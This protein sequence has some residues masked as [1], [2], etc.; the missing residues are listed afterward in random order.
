[1]NEQLGLDLAAEPSVDGV[2]PYWLDCHRNR[3]KHLHTTKRNGVWV[4]EWRAVS[5]EYRCTFR[6]Q[7]TVAS[8]GTYKSNRR[9]GR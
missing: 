9:E 1:M 7:H 4:E 3:W 5:D 8:C 2:C 6:Q